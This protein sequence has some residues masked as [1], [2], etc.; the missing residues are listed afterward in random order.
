MSAV[1]ELN[2]LNESSCPHEPTPIRSEGFEPEGISNEA[3]LTN[4][5][6]GGLSVIRDSD[7]KVV[8]TVPLKR[9]AYVTYD[10]GRGYV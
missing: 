9:P 7:N 5:G 2:F 3:I 6:N 1:A 8:Q 4:L 10:S